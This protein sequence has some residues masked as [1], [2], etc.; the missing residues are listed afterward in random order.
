M[1]QL[2]LRSS[3]MHT[4]SSF[5]CVDGGNATAAEML[6]EE[7]ESEGPDFSYLPETAW[8]RILEHLPMTD[9]YHVSITCSRLCHLFSHP[10][11]W[12][13]AYL[14][15]IGGEHNFHMS[16]AFMP[17]QFKRIVEHFGH[18]FQRLTIVISGHLV[19]FEEDTRE[20]LA[21]L[22][23][24][25]R[26]EHLVLQVGIVTSNFHRRGMRP[27]QADLLSIVQLVS[28]AFRL[29]Q[30][31]I[32]SWPMYP[33]IFDK[34]DT[35]VFEVMK[36]NPKLSNLESLR[37][38]WMKNR[39]WSELAPLLPSPDYTA[40]LVSHF[41]ALKHLALRSPMLSDELLSELASPSRTK[42]LSLQIL[43]MYNLHN[44]AFR[45]PTLSSSAW[46]SL[47]T[48]S[49][50][51]EVEFAIMSRV[52]DFELAG[53]LLPEVPVV[54]VKILKYGRCSPQVM[55]SLRE[56]YH[57]SLQSFVCYNDPTDCAS[58]LVDLVKSCKKINSV[59]FH[60][61]IHS[62]SVIEIVQQRHHWQ[63]FEFLEKSI[64]TE[65]EQEV[66][67]EDTVIGRGADG[68]LVQVGVVRFHGRESEDDRQTG[69][70]YLC[71]EVSKRMEYSWRPLVGQT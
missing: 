30:L 48:A 39:H 69:L 21:N 62:Q 14:G 71:K 3:E 33:E 52:P 10:A 9:Q 61:Q 8:V 16:H 37:M 32:I 55:S 46:L 54:A 4:D 6:H 43:V 60:G 47:T 19:K 24:V 35:N 1:E 7:V 56:K 64:V 65:R 20:I 11:L 40:S 34:D 22:T 49:P 15:L 45:I 25:C 23:K 13:S 67:D 31:E 29:K 42:L 58:Q 12:K 28:N 2:E 63:E 41:R 68:G 26:L 17:N 57:K 66:F 44:W 38:F 51:L 59:V 70:D 53:L 50:N 27:R 18:L 5:N 36:K